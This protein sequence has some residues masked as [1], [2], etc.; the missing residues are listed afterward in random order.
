M[1]TVFVDGDACP[2]KTEVAEVATRHQTR[3]LIVCNGGLRPSDN[4]LVE[5]I[6]VAEGLDVADHWIVDRAEDTDIVITADIPLAAE[7]VAKGARVLKP[8]GEILTPTNIGNILA[9]RDLMTG[10]READP[11]RP[12]SG[13]P[14]SKSDRA[15][16]RQKLDQTLRSLK[17]G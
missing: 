9:T 4:P 13:R 14:F 8:N 16:F 17:T 1:T 10:L 7:C 15:R 11:L 12:G 6:Y 3:V 5:V 2:V